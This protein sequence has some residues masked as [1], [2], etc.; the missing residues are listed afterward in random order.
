MRIVSIL[1]Q[2]PIA[3][4][5]QLDLIH[6]ACL[7]LSLSLSLCVSLP[8]SLCASLCAPSLPRSLRESLPLFL[9]DALREFEADSV[10]QAALGSEFSEGYLKL[11]CE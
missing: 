8:L 4:G 5:N 10:L 11:R 7:G 1:Q 9:I 2:G 3:L 6:R